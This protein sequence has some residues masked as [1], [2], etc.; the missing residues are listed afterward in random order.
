MSPGSFFNTAGLR[1]EPPRKFY[2]QGGRVEPF[3]FSVRYTY[4]RFATVG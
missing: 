2:D 4:N 3:M 1:W